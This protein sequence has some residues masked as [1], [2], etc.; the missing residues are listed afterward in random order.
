[1]YFSRSYNEVL[2][3]KGVNVDCPVRV[4]KLGYNPSTHRVEVCA[5]FHALLGLVLALAKVEH[6][7]LGSFWS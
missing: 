6:T 4:S 5:L 3:I 7:P 1:M 2:L